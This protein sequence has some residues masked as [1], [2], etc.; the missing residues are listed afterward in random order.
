MLRKG[1]YPFKEKSLPTKK[2]FCSNLTLQSIPDVDYK[3]AKRVWEHFE[4]QNL[5]QYQDLYTQRDTLLLAD[6]FE[7]IRK[8]CLEIDELDPALSLQHSD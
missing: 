6:V 7:S 4:V 3:H 1:V 5:G 2:E 8:L